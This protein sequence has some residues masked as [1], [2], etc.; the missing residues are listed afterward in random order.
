MAAFPPNPT[1]T[2]IYYNDDGVPYQYNSA[3]KTY[4]KLDSQI[5]RSAAVTVNQAALDIP[6][7]S[8]GEIRIRNGLPR[9]GILTTMVNVYWT[10]RIDLNA[11]NKFYFQFR[12][13]DFNKNLIR[14]EF[15]RENRS[16]FVQTDNFPSLSFNY[17]INNNDPNAT[18][19]YL[20]VVFSG[21]IDQTQS[22]NWIPSVWH[23]G[24]IE[25]LYTI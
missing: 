15:M 4:F 21:K 24:I 9:G 5:T 14:N 19:Y 18:A 22:G 20:E 1:N 6:S 8:L 16:D 2:A 13:K 11:N 3:S 10:E 12:F 17:T 23:F 25:K 7:T